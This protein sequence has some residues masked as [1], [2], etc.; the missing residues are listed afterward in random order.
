MM[1]MTMMM[2]MMMMMTTMMMMMKMMM[3]MMTDDDDDDDYYYYLSYILAMGA[4]VRQ[5]ARH[6]RKIGKEFY[7]REGGEIPKVAKN[8]RNWPKTERLIRKI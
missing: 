3:M 1:M 5:G 4:R 2:M 7:G 8:R 6:W